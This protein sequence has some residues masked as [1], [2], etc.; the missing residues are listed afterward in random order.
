MEV[1]SAIDEAAAIEHIVKTCLVPWDDVAFRSAF[2]GA[3]LAVCR[4]E[5]DLDAPETADRIEGEL[6]RSGYGAAMVRYW[7]SASEATGHVAHWEV[8]RNGEA[9]D[10]IK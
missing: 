2:D 10:G 6:R 1:T 4:T 8:R 5:L 9:P 3:L 7:R